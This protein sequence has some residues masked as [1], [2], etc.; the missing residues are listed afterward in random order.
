[1]QA[2]SE[3]EADG[4]KEKSGNDCRL[5]KRECERETRKQADHR[6]GARIACLR[7]VES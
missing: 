1:M 7:R 6:N 5:L 3:R 2:P 4:K